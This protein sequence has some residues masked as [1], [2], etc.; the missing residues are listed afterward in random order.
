VGAAALREASARNASRTRR[1]RFI[2]VAV[3]V[4]RREETKNDAV[5]DE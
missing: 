2:G 4:A 1:K 3:V 5:P